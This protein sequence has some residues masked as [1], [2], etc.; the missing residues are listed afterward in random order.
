MLCSLGFSTPNECSFHA[1]AA[2][3]VDAVTATAA[4]VGIAVVDAETTT[5]PPTITTTGYSSI[6]T[7]APTAT[8]A[9]A[10]AA[11]HPV[12][13]AIASKKRSHPET[14]TDMSRRR[15]QALQKS[16]LRKAEAHYRR[17]REVIALVKLVG[18]R[19][20]W[21]ATRGAWGVVHKIRPLYHTTTTTTTNTTITDTTT[22]SVDTVSAAISTSTGL[23]MSGAFAVAVAWGRRWKGPGGGGNGGEC[24]GRCIHRAAAFG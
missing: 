8:A 10:T 15:L 24:G 21:E 11:G 20:V 1:K 19:W 16:Q 7:V 9:I 3:A 4:A 12:D 6:T 17:R 22:V 13:V 18:T 14:T 23:S 2:V 5:F